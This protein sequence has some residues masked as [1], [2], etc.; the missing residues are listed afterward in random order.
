M[1][2]CIQFH[3]MLNHVILA[4]NCI[5]QRFPVLCGMGSIT[6]R[7][8]VTLTVFINYKGKI[9]IRYT[10]LCLFL[11]Y[12]TSQEICSYFI[13]FCCDLVWVIFTHIFKYYHF[14]ARHWDNCK[15]YID[16]STLIY[17]KRLKHP[18]PRNKMT[19]NN[20]GR[21]MGG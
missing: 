3:I 12:V 7:S 4:P 9:C 5:F 6:Q 15:V 11:N 1:Q 17:G 20:E 16:L 19:D 21:Q 13:V 14:T 18:F 8:P 2:F 10:T